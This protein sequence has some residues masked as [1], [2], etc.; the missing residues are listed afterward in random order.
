MLWLLGMLEDMFLSV[1]ALMLLE[2]PGL[3]SMTW[4]GREGLS[5]RGGGE[6]Q[7][8]HWGGGAHH[9]EAHRGSVG[10]AKVRK[11][12]GT[13]APDGV[14]SDTPVP[15]KRLLRNTQGRS[16]TEAGQYDNWFDIHLTIMSEMYV[17][18]WIKSH[19]KLFCKYILQ[20]SIILQFEE[21]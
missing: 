4:S 3:H 20:P 10:A 6:E 9:Q 21:C 1:N 19:G 5:G 18:W 16:E 13:M 2:S 12:K 15:P 7:G 14:T 8:V 17:F 11:R